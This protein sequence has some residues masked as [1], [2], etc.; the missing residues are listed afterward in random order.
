MEGQVDGVASDEYEALLSG[1]SP[2]R[3]TPSIDENSMAELFYTSG[4]TGFPRAWS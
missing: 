1:G 3:L 2:D 4:T